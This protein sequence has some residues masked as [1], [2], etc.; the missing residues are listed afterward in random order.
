[1]SVTDSVAPDGQAATFVFATT[2]AQ[3]DFVPQ[4]TVSR[5]LVS[6]EPGNRPL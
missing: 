2:F 6:V 4:P 1:M 3:A 5:P